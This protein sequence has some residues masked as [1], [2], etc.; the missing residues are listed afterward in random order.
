MVDHKKSSYN[1]AKLVKKLILLLYEISYKPVCKKFMFY[2]HPNSWSSSIRLTPIPLSSDFHKHVALPFSFK[3]K[4]HEMGGPLIT[5]QTK[6]KK[7]N[8]K[9]SLSLSLVFS[10]DLSLLDGPRVLPPN[11]AFSHQ[12]PSELAGTPSLLAGPF[13]K[14]F[15]STDLAGRRILPPYLACSRREPSDLAES[16][17]KSLSSHRLLP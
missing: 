4:N 14:L 6:G 16:R 13:R 2:Y 3:K 10:P 15:L 17:R 11:L 9:L 12:E 8:S 7:Q 1:C 5:K